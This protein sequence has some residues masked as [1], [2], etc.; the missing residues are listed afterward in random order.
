MAI[1]L[2]LLFTG[3]AM[4]LTAFSTY[5]IFDLGMREKARLNY[6]VG[7]LACWASARLYLYAAFILVYGIK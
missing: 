3:I 7:L 5:L 4:W 6:I 1:W 2:M